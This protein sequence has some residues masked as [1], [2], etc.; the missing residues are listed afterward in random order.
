MNNLLKQ[1]T[2]KTLTVTAKY[3]VRTSESNLQKD[4]SASQTYY[5][6]KDV[7]LMQQNINEALNSANYAVSEGAY[8]GYS[9]QF[10]L[11]FIGV[12]GDEGYKSQA[13]EAALNY[14]SIGNTFEKQSSDYFKDIFKLGQD[15]GGVT[16]NNN[17]IFMNSKYDDPRNTRNRIHEIFHTLFYKND[18]ADNGIG[19]YN[20]G[21]DMPNQKDINMLINNSGLPKMIE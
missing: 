14:I 2:T 11:E 12:P 17:Q 15:A 3:Y 9:V 20:P 4:L 7:P 13:R 5:K 10:H 18:D 21:Q 6:P 1:K 8:A 16:T 19:N